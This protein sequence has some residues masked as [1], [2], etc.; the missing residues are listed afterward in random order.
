MTER[1]LETM[2]SIGNS[3][4]LSGTRVLD[5]TDEKGYLCGRL[6]SELGAE[7]VKVEKPGGDSGRQCGPFYHDLPDYQKSLYWFAYNYNKRSITLNLETDD[8]RQTLKRLLEKWDIV[9]ESFPIGYLDEMGIGYKE[10]SKVNPRVI[11]TSISPFGQEGPYKTYKATDIELM[12]LGGFMSICGE[13][14]RAPVRIP[15]PQAYLFASADAALGTLIA[16]YWRELTGEGQQVDCAAQNS[17]ALTVRNPGYWLFQKEILP[18][19]GQFRSAHGIRQ[20]HMFPCKDGWISFQVIGGQAGAQTNKALVEYMVSEGFVSDFLNN[21]DW[22]NFDMSTVTQETM[23][24]IE[25]P[26]ET[27]FLAYTM[28][29]LEEEALKRDIILFPVNTLGAILDNPQLQARDYWPEVEHPELGITVKYP[30]SFVRVSDAEYLT[31]RI[32]HRAPLSGEHNEGFYREELGLMKE[33]VI[34]LRQAG[35]I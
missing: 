15:F 2:D 8:G 13:G 21:I 11:M 1:N 5:L 32:R 24:K 30:G 6:L 4:L 26:I 7:V 18:R 10:L 23:D 22:N 17:V 34:A 14:G 12:A 35:I 27:F 9:I 19:D 25:G 28:S 29:Q 31:P 20:H 3:G 33:E 16:C